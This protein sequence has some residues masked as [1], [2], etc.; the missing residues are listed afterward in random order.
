MPMAHGEVTFVLSPVDDATE[1]HISYIYAP[2]F[3]LL[4]QIKD[5][6]VLDGQFTK[7]MTGFLKDLDAAAQ[8]SG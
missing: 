4:G 8:Q 1:G 3:G 2:K 7:G 6:L 5:R